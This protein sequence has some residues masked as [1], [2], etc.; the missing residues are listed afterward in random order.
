MLGAVAGDI[1]G[2]VYEYTEQKRY[3]FEMLPKGSRFTDDSVMTIAVAHW[4]C[5]YIGEG[6]PEE[7]LIKT[8][9]KF[10]REYPYAGYGSTFNGWIWCE[11]P[12]PYQSWGNGAAMRVSPVGL[13]AETLVEAL[14]LAKRTAEVSHNHPEGI[15]GAQSVAS[16]VW[17]AR[18]GHTKDEIRSYITE[19]FHYDLSR[20]VDEIRPT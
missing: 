6:N 20:T 10:G 16:A 8:M 5:D 19:K 9:Q 18:H 11:Y 14:E 3:D 2:S 15:K 12:G 1:I 17:L 7:K 4:L 13:Y